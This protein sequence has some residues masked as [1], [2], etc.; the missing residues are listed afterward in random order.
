MGERQ[1]GPKL[2]TLFHTW[3]E[4]GISYEALI[5]RAKAMGITLSRSAV[6]RHKSR[7]L[8]PVDP[9]E[10]EADE[11]EEG[12]EVAGEG[13]PMSDIQ[14]LESLIA[15]GAAGL[16]APTSK[17]SAEMLMRAMELKY[18]LTQGNAFQGF[19]DAVNAAF[20]DED[21]PENPDASKSADEQAQAAPEDF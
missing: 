3:Y 9:S 11:R 17:V 16:R 4:E 7:H 12:A 19:L 13:P 5:A 18:K 10:L 15:R 2:A 1:Q 8:V 21:K 20:D 14:I 6:A